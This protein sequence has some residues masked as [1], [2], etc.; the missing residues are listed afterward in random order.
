MNGAF[1]V[2]AVGLDSQQRALDNIANNIAN[3]STPSFKRSDMRFT[4]IM[5]SR[6]NEI[7][8]PTVDRSQQM[9]PA[10]VV[11]RPEFRMLDQGD[12]RETGRSGDVAING[13]GFI[14]LLGPSG[15]V[16]LWRG[17]S[18]KVNAE[19]MLAA[20]NDMPL[21][22]SISIPADITD[23]RIATN[24]RVFGVVPDQGTEIEMGQINLVR[25]DDSTGVERLDGGLYA[26]G[27]GTAMTD[28]EP[29][30]DGAGLLVQGSIEGSNVDL[31]TE[32][33][34]LTLVQRAFASNAQIL[35]AADQ[36]MAITNGLRR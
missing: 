4:E 2:G 35:Q 33:V 28:V 10:G 18:L 22:A 21:R 14:E 3:I 20:S 16:L 8:A 9:V 30:E 11:S 17:G 26:L 1:Y 34:Q 27:S 23:F 13:A 25:L 36:L 31:A 15:Q 24:G 6:L 12:L 7:D 29:G 5:A 19:G 32:M